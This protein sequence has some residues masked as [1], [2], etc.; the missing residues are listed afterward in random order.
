MSLSLSFCVPA[1]L[2]VSSFLLPFSCPHPCLTAHTSL[3]SSL[4]P[5]HCCTSWHI[6]FFLIRI[7]SLKRRLCALSNQ[8]THRFLWY[9]YYY[10]VANVFCSSRLRDLL[11]FDSPPRLRVAH[12]TCVLLLPSLV[13]FVSHSHTAMN[14]FD[15]LS[16]RS[17][18]SCHCACSQTPS[19]PLVRL[20][21]RADN[22]RNL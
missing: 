18:T 20:L 12:S 3:P 1:F 2:G 10:H 8:S 4:G 11:L 13:V 19:F 14:A 6:H 16:C 9:S 17:G 7:S 22:F 5:E 21:V 15:A